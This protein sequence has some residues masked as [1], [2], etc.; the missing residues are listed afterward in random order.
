M[1]KTSSAKQKGRKLQQLVRDK[2]LEKFPEFHP[3]DV[4]STSMGAQGEDVQLSPVARKKL[5]IAIETKARNRLSVYSFYEQAL[6]HAAKCVIGS[7]VEPV[8]VIKQ[9]RD[10]PLVLISLEHYLTLLKERK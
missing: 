9:D 5:R 10:I 8:V 4:K 7:P 1:I 6:D 3:D 2:I